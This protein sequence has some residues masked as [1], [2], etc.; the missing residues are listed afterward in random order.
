[1]QVTGIEYLPD[2]DEAGWTRPLDGDYPPAPRQMLTFVMHL[3]P[4]FE[5]G[6][7]TFL[8]VSRKLDSKIP[9]RAGEVGWGLYYFERTRWDALDTIIIALW[10]AASLAFVWLVLGNMTPRG[11]RVLKVQGEEESCSVVCLDWTFTFFFV[12]YDY[13]LLFSLLWV[14]RR[15]AEDEAKELVVPKFTYEGISCQ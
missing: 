8:L 11:G 2:A 4:G 9:A 12:F 10:A 14:S 7:D 3:R 15:M 6:L 13:V 1:M 5:K